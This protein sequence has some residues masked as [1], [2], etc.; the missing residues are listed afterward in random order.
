[1][2]EHV[3][4]TQ[5]ALVVCVRRAG[6]DPPVPPVVKHINAHTPAQTAISTNQRQLLFPLL[7]QPILVRS[8]PK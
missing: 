6:R 8:T 2:V 5:R 4:K 7:L 1:M 3:L